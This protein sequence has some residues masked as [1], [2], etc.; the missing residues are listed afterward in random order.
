[1]QNFTIKQYSP[2]ETKIVFSTIQSFKGLEN[3]YIIV[4]DVDETNFNET[5][6]VALTRARYA[7]YIVGT[8]VLFKR[9]LKFYV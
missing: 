6:Y 4:C 3:D 7:L 1:M 9:M 8:K 2:D 5:L